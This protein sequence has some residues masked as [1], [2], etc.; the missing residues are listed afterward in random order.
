M[1]RNTEEQSE[2]KR[3]YRELKERTTPGDHRPKMQEA[4]DKAP[5][6][7]SDSFCPFMFCLPQFRSVLKSHVCSCGALH[8][9]SLKVSEIPMLAY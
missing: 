1:N 2:T 7:R 6:T 4:Y 3:Q 8:P 5:E 9:I